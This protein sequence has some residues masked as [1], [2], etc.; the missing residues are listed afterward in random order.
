MSVS[1]K[2]NLK[3]VTVQLD[4]IPKNMKQYSD[5]VL[6]DAQKLLLVQIKSKAPRKSGDYAKSWRIGKIT[7]NNAEVFTPMGKLYVILEF[8][9]AR[10]H[11][12]RKGTGQGVFVFKVKDGTIVFTKT[13]DNPGF[14]ANPHVRPA[15]KKVI[16]E[17]M[18]DVLFSHLDKVSTVFNQA[19]KPS[20][21]KV[22]KLKS[23][24]DRKTLNQ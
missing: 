6:K 24:T 16:N 5:L 3:P 11:K 14:K 12:Q 1:F 2:I 23:I 20:K 17:M 21:R 4:K 19:S 8:Q 18:K 10:P 15:L 9:G 13:I 7:G 22:E